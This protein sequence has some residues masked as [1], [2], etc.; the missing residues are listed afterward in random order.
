MPP[1]PAGNDVGFAA[2]GSTSRL[3][4]PQPARPV[5][6]RANPIGWLAVIGGGGVALGV[7]LP[8]AQAP[9][10]QPVTGWALGEWWFLLLAGFAVARGLSMA[11]PER[12]NLQMGTPVIGGAIILFFGLSRLNSL[13]QQLGSNGSPR[14]GIYVVLLGGGLVTLAGL[15]QLLGDRRPR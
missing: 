10:Y 4:L 11:I 6:R 2:S 12:F 5:G 15:L 8:W 14:I 3:G 13:K 1:P 9:G 7:F